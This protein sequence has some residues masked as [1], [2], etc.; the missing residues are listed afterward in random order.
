M[1]TFDDCLCLFVGLITWF[2]LLCGLWIDYLVEWLV[3][4]ML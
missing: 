3:C 1:F 2:G 4:S